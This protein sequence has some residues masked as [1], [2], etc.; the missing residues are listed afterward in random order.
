MLRSCLLLV[1]GPD[2]SLG[3]LPHP[4]LGPPLQLLHHLLIQLLLLPLV[5]GGIN[6]AWPLET[7]RWIPGLVYSSLLHSSEAYYM[8][9]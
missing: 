1:D 6:P 3:G 4:T 5:P 7:T 2:E 8:E 9:S